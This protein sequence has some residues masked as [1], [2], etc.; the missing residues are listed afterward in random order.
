MVR[1]KIWEWKCSGCNKIINDIDEKNID[2]KIEEH[3][4]SCQKYKE[5]AKEL[6]NFAKMV[7]DFR[8]AGGDLDVLRKILNTDDVVKSLKRLM[9]KYEYTPDDVIEIC[10]ML[11]D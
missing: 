8:D 5:H 11:N 2:K 3:K 9:K 10:E 6:T 1:V 4:S 7:V